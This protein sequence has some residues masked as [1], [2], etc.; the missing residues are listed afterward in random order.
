MATPLMGAE[1]FSYV[2]QRIPGAMFALGVMPAER[3][4]SGHVAP[5]ASL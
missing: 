5:V 4:P 2:L 1:D 3:D